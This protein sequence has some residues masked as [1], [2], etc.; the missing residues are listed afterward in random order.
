MDAAADGCCPGPA[1]SMAGLVSEPVGDIGSRGHADLAGA[2]LEQHIVVCLRECGLLPRPSGVERG[3]RGL[4]PA[5]GS[6][7]LFFSSHLDCA[8]FSRITG[9]RVHDQDRCERLNRSIRRETTKLSR[10]QD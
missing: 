8:V 3:D 7:G 2:A 1:Y 5:A 6:S 10:D 9:F 4:C